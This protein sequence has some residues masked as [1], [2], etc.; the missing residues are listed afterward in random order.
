MKP[1]T[2]SQEER[3]KALIMATIQ[4]AEAQDLD[5]LLT[6]TTLVMAGL[7]MSIGLQGIA[8]TRAFILN[9]LHALDDPHQRPH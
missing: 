8:A 7:G 4:G 1:D 2:A 3:V 6:A 5:R 9:A